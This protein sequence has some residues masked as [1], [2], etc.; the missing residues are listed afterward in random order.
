MAAEV[1]R[2]NTPRRS[3]GISQEAERFFWT[4]A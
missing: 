1:R 3:R 2:R 4:R